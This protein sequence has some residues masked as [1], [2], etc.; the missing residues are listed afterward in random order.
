MNFDLSEPTVT[1]NDELVSGVHVQAS[2]ALPWRT[3]RIVGTAL[4]QS[5][6]VTASYKAAPDWVVFQGDIDDARADVDATAHATARGL[7]AWRREV[8]PQGFVDVQLDTLLG[9]IA[10]QCGGTLD[11]N[12]PL[13][14]RRHYQLT[15]G[16]AHRAVREALAAWQLDLVLLELDGGVLHVGPEAETPH[17]TAGIQAHLARGDNIT[18]L[19]ERGGGRY[20]VTT[21]AMPWL[22]VSHRITLDHP[23]VT[24]PA[25]ITDVRLVMDEHHTLT[26]LEVIRL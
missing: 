23:L 16:P 6:E 18:H 10:E 2:L 14:T 22:R 12:V 20:H 25:R 4:P 13:V 19:R 3:A 1:V 24:G 11:L 21:P 7:P 9:W 26:E 5:V 17:A 15:R 8:G